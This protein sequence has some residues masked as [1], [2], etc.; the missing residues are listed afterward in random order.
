MDLAK[1]RNIGFNTPETRGSRALH[2]QTEILFRAGKVVAKTMLM[3]QGT[4]LDVVLSTVPEGAGDDL[5][6][7]T[8]FAESQ[9]GSVLADVSR[10]RYDNA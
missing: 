7:I 4:V 6:T 2:V 5:D 3:E 8:Q 9:H 10:G 1:L